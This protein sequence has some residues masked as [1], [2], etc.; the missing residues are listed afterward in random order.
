MGE[1]KKGDWEEERRFREVRKERKRGVEE[2][3]GERK[4]RIGGER[5]RR[6]GGE[7]KRRIGGG[8]EV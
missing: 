1:E 6:I 7:R 5:K 2:G 3:G 8:G 4:R